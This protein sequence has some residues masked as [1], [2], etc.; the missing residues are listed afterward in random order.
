M[1]PPYPVYSVFFVSIFVQSDFM[2]MVRVGYHICLSGPL[3][4]CNVKN[5]AHDHFVLET[6]LY[7]IRVLK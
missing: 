6:T 3:P 1:T 7:F 5:R 4:K 2:L